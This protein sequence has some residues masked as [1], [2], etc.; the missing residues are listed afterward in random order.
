M[1]CA[2]EGPYLWDSRYA[3]LVAAK[4]KKNVLVVI[5]SLKGNHQ[6]H[7]TDFNDENIIVSKNVLLHHGGEIRRG[8]ASLPGKDV[9][10][11]CHS[12]DSPGFSPSGLSTPGI[13]LQTC[14][15]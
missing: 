7:I 6:I 2:G 11:T 15:S 3:C 4:K 13:V 1:A 9:L 12:E 14:A 8:N 10:V 5:Q